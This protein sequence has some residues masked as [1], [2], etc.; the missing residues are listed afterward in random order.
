MLSVP[1][2]NLSVATGLV[3]TLLL[4]L[5]A[6]PAFAMGGKLHH[7]TAEACAG[8]HQEIYQ[9]WKGSMHAN[10]SA[11][12]DP[13]HGAMY[14][15]VAGDPGMEG[16]T[17]NGKYPVCLNCHAPAA[18]MDGKTNLMALPAY[19]DGVTCVTCHAME[20][21]QGI[22]S[23]SGGMKLGVKAYS[24][25]EELQGPS[26]IDRGPTNPQAF[27]PV[28]MKGNSALMRGPDACLGC[29]DQ[30]NNAHQVPL[31]MTGAEFRQADSFNCQQCHM[32]VK[33]GANGKARA[34][35]TMAG[36]HVPG[37]VER[38][39]VLTVK[40]DKSEDGVNATVTL[41]NMLPHNVP[42]GAPFRNMF[43]AVTGLDASGKEIWKNFE[44]HPIKEDP[45]SMFMLKLLE[46]DDSPASPPTAK[47]L[48]SDTRLKPN[49]TREIDYALPAVVTAV[50]AELYYDL[51]LPPLKEMLKTVPSQLKQSQRVAFAEV[52]L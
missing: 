32:A 14:R 38:S 7:N 45:K 18:A 3:G 35:H 16:V 36:G 29:H 19:N 37:M 41:R 42:T 22:H 49:E 46:N 23:E 26:G 34:D 52:K 10:A 30:R 15:K 17:N 25:S 24:M 28:P 40:A 31:C 21:Y 27:H 13:I 1:N 39:V 50:R 5:A 20:S 33:I 48:G 8:C 12:K 11:L 4:A 51:L 6:L 44:K 9:E 47:K 43:L 2:R